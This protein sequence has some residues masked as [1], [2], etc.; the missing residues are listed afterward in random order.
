MTTEETRPP[1]E[2]FDLD[3]MTSRQIKMRFRELAVGHNELCGM[4]CEAQ[5]KIAMLQK[6]LSKL[7][8]RV[9][10]EEQDDKEEA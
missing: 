1:N 8:R 7:E 4:W 2:P 9:F 6:R 5:D 10:G 3:N